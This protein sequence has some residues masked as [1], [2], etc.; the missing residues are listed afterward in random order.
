M[1]LF[2]VTIFWASRVRGCTWKMLPGHSGRR[3][4]EQLSHN[5]VEHIAHQQVSLSCLWLMR[6]PL[7]YVWNLQV[8]EQKTYCESLRSSSQ[9]V[10]SRVLRKNGPKNFLK[11]HAPACWIM[12]SYHNNLTSWTSGSCFVNV[13]NP[14]G[15]SVFYCCLLTVHLASAVFSW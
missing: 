3:G 8:T 2:E 9:V 15:R 4:K 12:N 5:S 7:S 6:K 11:R 13:A 14:R 1:D 10:L